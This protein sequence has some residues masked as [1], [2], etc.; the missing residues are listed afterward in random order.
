MNVLKS[1]KVLAAIASV[2]VALATLFTALGDAQADSGTPGFTPGSVKYGEKCAGNSNLGF[3]IE[4]GG[5]TN[6]GYYAPATRLAFVNTG[7][8][9]SLEVW[10]IVKV[11]EDD[12]STWVYSYAQ[13]T[14]STN[15]WEFDYRSTHTPTPIW[16]GT[17]SSNSTKHF[18][19]VPQI[20]TEMGAQMRS[21]VDQMVLVFDYDVD[22]NI[23]LDCINV[24]H[25]VMIPY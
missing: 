12:S 8:S 19:N 4:P 2:L 16:S 25:D 18:L 3:K 14:G 7:A 23:D 22:G 24:I 21:E 20:L 15:N 10:A 13:N 17:L 9:Q 1:K 11:D 5:Y 6:S